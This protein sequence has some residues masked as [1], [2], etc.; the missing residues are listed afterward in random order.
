[1][2]WWSPNRCCSSTTASE[3]S[4]NVTASWTSACVPTT[5]STLP[6]AT[7]SRTRWRSFPVTAA[8]RSAHVT[9]GVRVGSAC[10]RGL[11]AQRRGATALPVPAPA[12]SRPRAR[13]TAPRR[14]A[15]RSAAT[16]RACWPAS[17]SVGAM[18]AAWWPDWI[19][20]SAAWS[21]TSVLPAPT[22]PCRSTFIGRGRGHRR[23]DLADRAALRVGGLERERRER[24]ARST[25]PPGSCA[26]PCCSASTR[27]LRNATP[28]SSTNS[29]SNFSRSRAPASCRVVL[30]EVDA[31]QGPV[32]GAEPLGR[33]SRRAASG[34][35]PA[36]AV[37]TPGTRARGSCGS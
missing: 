19:A 2:R 13:G 12:A 34:R 18:I 24:A 16:D 32:V 6:S 15:S 21:A 25:G 28:S 11:G 36:R 5:R 8:V 17:T 23:V 37:R 29:S 10:R 9:R 22:S 4:A 30:G 14:R 31:A 1:M 26:T 33:R 20:T 27:C 3:R 7:P 35:G